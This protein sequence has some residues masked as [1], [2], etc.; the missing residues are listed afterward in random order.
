MLPVQMTATST[1][2]AV[3]QELLARYNLATEAMMGGFGASF[4]RIKPNTLD[5][6]LTENGNA[7][8]VQNGHVVGVLLGIAPHDHCVWYAKDYVPG[9]EPEEPDLVWVWTTQDTFP[10]ALPEKY[11]KKV[12][13]NGKERWKF[14]IAR[15][16]VWALAKMNA[17]NQMMLDLDNPYIM[18]ITSMSMYGKGNPEAG[19][20]KYS[21]L[22]NFCKR[23]SEPPMIQCSP[24]MFL[25]QILLDGAAKLAGVV[26]FRPMMAADNVNPQYLD[27]ATFNQVLAAMF[28]QNVQEAL[29]VQEK[30]TPKGTTQVTHI[31][32]GGGGFVKVNPAPQEVIDPVQAFQQTTPLRV[33]AESEP[34]PEQAV[35][36]SV[37]AV[38]PKPAANPQQPMTATPNADLMRQAE[39]VLGSEDI[40][41]AEGVSSI[42]GAAIDALSGLI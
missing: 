26:V 34:G 13:I 11:R 7:R 1:A 19:T 40:P 27:E 31:G 20:Y 23:F 18:D 17:N 21:G 10:D 3:P 29:K 41:V 42:T 35:G 32:E 12:L 6:T 16:S 5:F 9:Q 8:Q 4:N 28:S 36:L 33:W 24:S 37:V 15:R 30:L 22:V 2:P 14:Q 25:T 38:V 39:V